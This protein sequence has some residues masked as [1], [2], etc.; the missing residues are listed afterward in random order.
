MLGI[1][2]PFG[3]LDTDI[4][5]AK[6]KLG[7][8]VGQTLRLCLLVDGNFLGYAPG[9]LDGG[10][11]GHNFEG[12][13]Y[14]PLVV[15]QRNAAV[16]NIQIQA[17]RRMGIGFAA[18]RL[19]VAY[20]L[21]A[22]AFVGFAVR[23]LEVVIALGADHLLLGFATHPGSQVIHIKDVE[24][25]V[26]DHGRSRHIVQQTDKAGNGAIHPLYDSAKISLMAA[27]IGPGGYASRN[28][29]LGQHS[30]VLDQQ[31]DGFCQFI[32]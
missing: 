4:G 32:H 9:F 7:E 30:R 5:V 15:A 21:A 19:A 27:G 18:G 24:V 11:V 2:I 6:G 8:S 3:G 23:C 28:C 16:G 17:G 12:A 26:D 1:T 10:L 29:R 20:G 14:F 13:D 31:L 22:G 25:L